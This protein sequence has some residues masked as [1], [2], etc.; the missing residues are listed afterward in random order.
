DKLTIPST[1]GPV[2]GN[3]QEDKKGWQSN[4]KRLE[5]A[6]AMGIEYSLSC[7][8]GGEGTEGDIVSQSAEATAKVI[9][10]VMEVSDPEIPKLFKLS[11][12]VTS[13]E[14]IMEAVKETLEQ[15]PNKKAGVTLANTF[16]VLGFEERSKAKWPDGVVLG[17]SGEGVA[18]ISYFTLA[19]AVPVGVPISGN[20]G[21]MDYLQSANF[22]AL[23]AG[24]VQYCTIVMKY[25]YGII[26]ELKNGVSFLM[27]ERGLNSM[28]E[29]IGIAQP[30]PITDFM[31]LSDT[32]KISS[33]IDPDLCL[34][35]G[36]CARCPYLAITLDDDLKPVMDPE[37][38]IGCSI[39]VQKC[40]SGALEMRERTPEEME[41]LSEE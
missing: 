14:T 19:R 9:G 2:T 15:Y 30:D 21:L 1:G 34:S 16:P 18:P 33:L 20:G 26:D 32:K 27:K 6:G 31:D 24:T 40:F 4:T 41:Q 38:C 28:K 13:I 37:K 17:M 39:C 7:P 29:L 35:C 5:E 12:A 36:N 8:Q 11:A 25:G 3:D 22:L 10:W 23:G